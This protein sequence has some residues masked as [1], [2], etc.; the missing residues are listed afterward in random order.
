MGRVYLAHDRE[1]DAEVAVKVVKAGPDTDTM[2]LKRFEREIQTLRRIDH[3]DILRYLDHGRHGDVVFL[4]VELL[5]GRL[6]EHAAADFRGQAERVL[7]LGARLA[8][9]LCAAHHKGV[10]HR[11][12][13]PTNILITE[14]GDPKILDYG[15]ARWELGEDDRSTTQ[16]MER[17][18]RTDAVL[19]TIPYMSPEQIR[20]EPVD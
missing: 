8:R 18:T 7:H 14:R 2:R 5:K 6:L 13:K 9:A 12:L 19:G 20:G 4:T 15:L 11:D 3:P 1:R 10:I 16:T 17:L